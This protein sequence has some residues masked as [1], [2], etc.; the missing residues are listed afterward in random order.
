MCKTFLNFKGYQEN[1]IAINRC[2]ASFQLI[3]FF[4]YTLSITVFFIFV[5]THYAENAVVILTAA[6][7]ANVIT[8]TAMASVLTTLVKIAD[9]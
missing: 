1:E 5:I 6:N 7:V 3:S 8:F 2:Q 4:L 9:F